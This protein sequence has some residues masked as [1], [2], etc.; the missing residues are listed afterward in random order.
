LGE[1]RYYKIVREWL[2]NQG[3]YCGGNITIGG[4]K[5]NYYQDIGTK[6]R[7]ADVAGI[8]N[9]GSRYADQI[10]IVAVEVRDKESVSDQDLRDTENYHQYA[11]KCYLATTAPISDK[12][13]QMAE[14]RNIGLLQLE[15]GK[16]GP[17]LIHSTNPSTP[18]D[19]D[20]MM[21][22]LNSFQ[23]VK[24]AVCGCYFERF[25]RASENYRS[26][27]E[28][29]RARYFDVMKDTDKDPLLKK[30]ID[31]LDAEHKMLVYVCQPCVQDLFLASTK[32]KRRMQTK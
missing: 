18:K 26:F 10:E 3:Y 22:F 21:K 25:I 27:L 13:K 15:R 6:N 2:E 32:I 29:G 19:P 11:H 16:K 30:D 23:I 28:L 8:K 1:K 12:H 20:E 14:R 24:C 7:R 9:V 17:R 31:N 4:G 5:L